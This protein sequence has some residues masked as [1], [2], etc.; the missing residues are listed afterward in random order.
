[1]RTIA[2]VVAVALIVATAAADSGCVFNTTNGTVVDLNSVGQYRGHA[3]GYTIDISPCVK[4]NMTDCMMSYG[5]VYKSRSSTCFKTAPS[6]QFDAVNNKT[7]F[8]FDSPATT[9]AMLMQGN[10]VRKLRT[11][12]TCDP[13]AT[14]VT[15]SNS[16]YNAVKYELT[17]NFNTA[18]ACPASPTPAPTTTPAPSVDHGGDDDNKLSTWAIVGII[19]GCV[20]AIV[21]VAFVCFK[22]RSTESQA[23]GEYARV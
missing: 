1:M 6:R 2:T 18:A 10:A 17:I 12:Y 3:A 5:G 7:S 14:N 8:V 20:V 16:N 22:C 9:L 21:I 15:E 11:T 23:E 13:A 19:A 4:V